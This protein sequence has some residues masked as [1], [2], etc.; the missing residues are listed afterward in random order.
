MQQQGA[1]ARQNELFDKVFTLTRSYEAKVSTSNGVY[2]I[3]QPVSS[4]PFA[5]SVAIR[6]PLVS[7]HWGDYWLFVYSPQVMCAMEDVGENSFLL[8]PIKAKET[9]DS[10][11]SI[12][13]E[14]VNGMAAIVIDI[15]FI[16]ELSAN[17]LVSIGEAQ[18][19]IE[20]TGL[21]FA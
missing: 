15:E 21:E 8:M 6:D 4:V 9:G 13:V 3:D 7:L 18:W 19:Q 20:I 2:T 5:I 12:E 14:D 1:I 10:T 11:T 17:M 16:S